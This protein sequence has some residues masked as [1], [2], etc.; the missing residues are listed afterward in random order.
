V[1]HNAALCRAA[2]RT[3]A[4]LITL[5]DRVETHGPCVRNGRARARCAIPRRANA[6][7]EVTSPDA[8]YVAF[9]FADLLRCASSALASCDARPGFTRT[10]SEVNMTSG[11][12]D[13]LPDPPKAGSVNYGTYLMVPDLLALQVPKSDPPEHDEMLF[14]IIHQVYE[15]WFKLVL[16]E[17]DKVQR[18]LFANDPWPALSTM[19]RVR[20]VMKVLVAQLDILE[21]MT[22]LEFASFR[23][24]L[25]QASGFQSAQF[26]EVEFL[27][28]HKRPEMLKFHTEGSESRRRLEERLAQPSLVDAFYAFLA[29]QGVPVPAA[30]LARDKSA[31]NHVEPAL[32]AHLVEVYRTRPDLVLLLE[33]MTDLDEGI[34]EWRY[35]HVKMVE[36][37]IGA[38]MGTG[39]SAGAEYLRRTL[40]TPLFPDLWAIR[41]MM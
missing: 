1:R 30:L 31:P 11:H 17:L 24:R 32:H 22:P 26:R 34:Q 40:F 8:L 15:L 13:N 19:K 35:R 25:D 38:K 14:I 21:T 28:G 12:D 41:S 36:R 18:N 10:T 2:A 39:G 5:D 29:A 4:R 33:A 27:L 3:H 23:S 6:H 37:T 16:H 9:E 20:H 7:S